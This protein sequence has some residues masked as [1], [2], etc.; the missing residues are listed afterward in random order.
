MAHFRVLQVNLEPPTLKLV[1]ND[2]F[3]LA[4]CVANSLRDKL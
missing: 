3:F 1:L 4:T 2:A